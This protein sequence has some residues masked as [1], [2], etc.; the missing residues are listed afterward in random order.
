MDNTTVDEVLR[1]RFWLKNNFEWLMSEVVWHR[2]M[3]Q[4]FDNPRT[5]IWK[6]GD[7]EGKAHLPYE[8]TE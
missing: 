5:A 2:D 3:K 1:R 6:F 8:T 7:M 4:Y